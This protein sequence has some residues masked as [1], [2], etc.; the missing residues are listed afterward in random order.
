MDN[1]IYEYLIPIGISIVILVIAYLYSLKQ[2]FYEYF[3]LN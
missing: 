1:E 2:S 3:N